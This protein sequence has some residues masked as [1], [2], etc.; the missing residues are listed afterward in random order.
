MVSVKNGIS[1]VRVLSSPNAKA[2]VDSF[3]IEF[4]RNCK[5]KIKSNRRFIRYFIDSVNDNI[6]KWKKWLCA[7]QI[8]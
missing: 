1:S 8:T 7:R 2:M 3:L 6:D 4:N 5:V